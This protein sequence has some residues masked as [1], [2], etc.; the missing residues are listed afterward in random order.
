MI[1][2]QTD[3][4]AH[5]ITDFDVYDPSLAV[6]TDVFQERVAAL[7]RQGAILYSPHH[8]GHWVVTR[9]KEALQVLQDAETFSSFPNN[10]LN[11]AQG[12][13]LP[14]ELDPPEHSYYRQALQPLFSPKRMKA[15]EPEIRRI[16]SELID[17][18]AH[19][20]ECEFIAEF[21]HELPTRIFLALMG[22]PLGDAPQFT[23]WTDITLQG[24]PGATE[25]E[26]AAAR[27]KAA[28]EI[29]EYFGRV[30]AQVRS[31]E[32]RSE[33]LT[34]Q[35][36]NTPLDIQGTPRPLSDEEL[37]RMFFLLLVAGL[38]TV[39]GALAWG[40]IHLSRNPEQRE[41]IVDDPTLIPSAVEEILRI[42]TATSAGRRA[43]RDVRIGGV[44]VKAGDQLLVVMT[45]ANRDDD[46]FD[47]PDELR[48]ERHPNRHIG[49]GAG[50][51]RCLGS[52]LARL[53][54]TLAL[55]EIHSRIPDYALVPGDPAVF[56]SSQVR[57]CAKLPI[58]F[59]PSTR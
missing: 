10:L 52:H 54:L 1:T 14:L 5:L 16:I 13:F 38:H 40:L 26:S 39:Q 37:C 51:H 11:A 21:A 18:F 20:G 27:A 15:L 34:A 7:R 9:Y 17:R 59:T 29:Y 55:E 25:E 24:I 19:K 48:I 8:G 49:F 50:P 31:G 56:H 6:P 44:S 23:E 58:T 57:G 30:V 33:T 2:T 53:E 46:E 43:T 32:N 3:I 41:A 36:I 45:A 4:P 35:I 28:A 12:K 42:E 22:W 47:S